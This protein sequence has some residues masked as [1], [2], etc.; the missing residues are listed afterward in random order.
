MPGEADLQIAEQKLNDV[1]LSGL[2]HRTMPSLS[3]G[4]RQLVLVARALT[5]QPKLLLLDEPTSHLDLS[6]KS[7]LIQVL[8]RG[9]RAAEFAG[10]FAVWR[11]D[12]NAEE[13]MLASLLHDLA[14][15]LGWCFAPN[16]MLRI[17][18]MQSRDAALRSDAAQKQVL[19]IELNE[20]QIALARRWRLPSL[21]VTLMDDQD[22][23]STRL[24]SSHIPLSRM[25]SSA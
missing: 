21:L 12:V 15:M 10:E 24:N 20:L 11:N 18:E 13:I 19:N 8:R 23:K 1:G 3:G 5:Q 9:Q 4:E 22:R 2:I 14:E 17:R 16:L 7:R 25:P 6:N